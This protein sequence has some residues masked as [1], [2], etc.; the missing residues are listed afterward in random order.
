MDL[1]RAMQHQNLMVKRK[2]KV[3]TKCYSRCTI[4]HFAT[5]QVGL[6]I[7]MWHCCLLIHHHWLSIHLKDISNIPWCQKKKSY[8]FCMF[9]AYTVLCM[10]F[11]LQI[12][13]TCQENLLWTWFWGKLR[14]AWNSCLNMDL[15]HVH[16]LVLKNTCNTKMT[17]CILDIDTVYVIFN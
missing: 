9:F 10:L 6:K 5:G 17:V 1:A 15:G 8:Y 7:C 11:C 3:G 16:L 4:C 14:N 2:H 12:L 13:T